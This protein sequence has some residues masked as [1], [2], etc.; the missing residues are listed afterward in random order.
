[1]VKTVY[2][3]KTGSEKIDDLSHRYALI[4][5]KVT[6]LTKYH[7]FAKILSFDYD[8]SEPFY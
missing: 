7:C 6:V 4:Y 1:M 2:F 8:F 5:R 3:S